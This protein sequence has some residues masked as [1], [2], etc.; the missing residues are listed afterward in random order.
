MNS[1]LYLVPVMAS[2]L[3]MINDIKKHLFL[4]PPLEAKSRHV[5][6]RFT[7]SQ[8]ENSQLVFDAVNSSLHIGWQ[9]R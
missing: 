8:K 6:L 1:Q 7:P 9:I 4:H 3:F 2:S 5:Y